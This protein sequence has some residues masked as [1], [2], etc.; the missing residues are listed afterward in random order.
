MSFFAAISQV[1]GRVRLEGISMAQ[2]SLASRRIESVLSMPTVAP[3]KL[4]RSWLVLMGACAAVATGLVA[5]VHPVL[6]DT[7]MVS[8]DTTPTAGTWTFSHGDGMDFAVVTSG[9]A[10]IMNG[11]ED[12]R[13][14]AES[15][16]SKVPG[17]FIWFVHN[18]NSYVIRDAATVRAARQLYAPMEALGQQQEA[19]GKKQEA[20]GKRQEALGQKMEAVSVTVPADLESR[21]KSLESA[22]QKLGP[23]GSQQQLSDLQEQIGQLQSEIGDVQS[24]AGRAQ[25]VLGQQQGELGRKQGE[26]GRQQGALGR[27]QGRLARQASRKMQ[28]ILQQSL[29]NGL[30]QRV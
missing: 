30:A 13:N 17:D 18:G 25:S 23:T 4:R 8:A 16:Q 14:A 2:G 12:D 29:T 15:L 5:A 20:L 27:E 19:L 7:T 21:L 24:H 1:R 10:T 22:V 11:S 28:G 9:R 26:L 6:A 3:P